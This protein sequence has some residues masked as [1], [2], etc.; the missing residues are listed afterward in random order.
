MENFHFL[1]LLDSVDARSKIASLL[2][3]D[4]EDHKASRSQ[5]QVEV[6]RHIEE[7]GVNPEGRSN[8]GSEQ[9]D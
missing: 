7:G 6:K 3:A 8:D 5:K 4:P 9:T 2:H 1:L